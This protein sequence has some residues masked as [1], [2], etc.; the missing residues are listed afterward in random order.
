MI[1]PAALR[2]LSL[3]ADT[4]SVAGAADTLGITPSA[5]SQQIK[6]L[7][8]ALDVPLLSRAG[9][10]VVLTA[11]GHSLAAAAPEVFAALERATRRCASP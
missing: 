3:I 1:D 5:V 4:G 10:G 7:E 9:R 2:A 6:R 11:A 8:A